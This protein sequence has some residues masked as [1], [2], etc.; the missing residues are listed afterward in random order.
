M[1][2][3]KTLRAF[4]QE[5]AKHVP[6]FE[7]RFKSDSR[8]QKL[9]GWLMR[10]FN[11]DYMTKYTSTFAPVV[12]FPTKEAYE[13]NPRGSLSTLAHEYVHLHDTL[14]S[15]WWFRVSYL[16]PQLLGPVF[17]IAFSIVAWQCAWIV[18]AM[19]L[20]VLGALVPGQK[21]LVAFILIAVA[22]VLGAGVMAVVMAGW[23]SLLFFAGLL[24]MLP[25]PSPGRTKWELRG[26]SM[27]VSVMYW[28]LGNT[29]KFAISS[30]FQRD[31]I[32]RQFVGPAYYF[33]SWN[34]KHVL[35]GLNGAVERAKN[36]SA[37]EDEPFRVTHNFI[38]QNIG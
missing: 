34:S 21:S 26:Y 14:Q 18:P 20:C 19:L 38:R 15:P 35:G 27:T 37:L 3:V 22:A 11:P 29:D 6:G 36:G 32:L 13:A 9:L 25:W 1:V 7:V 24:S 33:M 8:S 28:L 17:L 5:I 30:A 16:L 4:E 2:E 31:F 23:W 10:P 12:Y